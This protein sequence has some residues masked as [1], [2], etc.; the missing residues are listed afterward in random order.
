MAFSSSSKATTVC[1]F[2]HLELT[3][4]TDKPTYGSVRQ[5]QNKELYANATTIPSLLGWSL[6]TRHD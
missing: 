1:T 5:L 3:I 2:P 6:G 4:I